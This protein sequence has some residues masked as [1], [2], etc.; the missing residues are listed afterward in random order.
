MNYFLVLE[1]RPKDFM[2]IN[3]NIIAR[4]NSHIYSSLQNIDEFTRKYTSDEIKDMIKENNLVTDDYLEGNLCV[5]NENKYRYKLFTKDVNM[6]M[7]TFLLDNIKNKQIMNKFVN[8]YLK[9]TNDNINELKEAIKNGHINIILQILFNLD[10][11]TIRNIYF[12]LY[13]NCK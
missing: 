4:D 6:S 9:Y 5:I 11:E 2:P 3:I 8:I 12:Y 13:E 10:Y 1:K 7:D